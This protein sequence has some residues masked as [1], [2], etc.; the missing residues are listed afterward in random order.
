MFS[1]QKILPL[2][3]TKQA[4]WKVEGGEINL[5]TTPLIDHKLQNTF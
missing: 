5:K 3:A 4:F 1:R 2:L